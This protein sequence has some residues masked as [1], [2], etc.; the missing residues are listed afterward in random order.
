MH[1]KEY[2]ISGLSGHGSNTTTVLNLG[3]PEEKNDPKIV[4][5]LKYLLESSDTHWYIFTHICTFPKILDKHPLLLRWLKY[6][7]EIDLIVDTSHH[8]PHALGSWD[9]SNATWYFRGQ[10]Q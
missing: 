1:A 2:I 6:L 9:K 5:I 3:G 7:R 4:I 8:F 10:K